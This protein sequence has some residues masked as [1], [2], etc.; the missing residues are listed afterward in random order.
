MKKE[1]K[2]YEMEKLAI[3]DML[4]QERKETAEKFAKGV[5]KRTLNWLGEMG[6]FLTYEELD[7]LTKSVLK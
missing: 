7:E 6:F 2:V 1:D 3:E 4:T 5:K